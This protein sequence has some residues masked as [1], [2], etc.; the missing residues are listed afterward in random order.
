MRRTGASLLLAAL[1]AFLVAAL[2]VA[3]GRPAVAFAATAP[4]DVAALPSAGS[5]AVPS[6]HPAAGARILVRFTSAATAADEATAIADVGGWVDAAMPQLDLTRIALPVGDDGSAALIALEGDALVAT[7]ELDHRAALRFDPNDPYYATD[8]ITGLGQWGIRKALVNT[9]WDQ[10]RGSANVTVA[11]LDTG[12]DPGHPDLVSALVPGATFVSQPSTGCDPSATQ[13][14]DS[15]GTHVAGIIGASGNNGVGI[16]GVAFGVKIMAIK[17]LDCQGIGSLSDVAQGMVYAVDHGARIVNLSLGSP[18]DSTALQSAVQYATAKNVLVVSAAGN[19]GEMTGSCTSVDQIEYPA[20]YPQVLAVGATDTDDSIAFF[21]TQNSTVDV[22]APGRRIVSTTPRYATYLSARG[23]PQNYAAFSGTSQASPFVAGVAALILSGEPT[24]GPAQLMQR[25]ESTADQLQG[26]QGTRNDAYGYGRVNAF[27]AVAAGATVERFGATYDTSALPK[28][29]GLGAAYTAK[30]TVTNTSTFTWKAVDPGSTRLGWSF[31]GPL[32][33]PTGI[34]GSVPLPG[35]VL[36]GASA[37]V[38]FPVVAPTTA[39]PYLFRLDLSRAG[40]AF[41]SKGV[42]PGSLAVV[43]GS[44]IGATY[45]PTAQTS[46][47]AGTASFS[48]G[49]PSSVSV[50]VTN[51]GTTT[52]AAGG[53]TPVHLSYHWLQGGAVVVWDGQRAGLPSDVPAGA[54]VTVSLGVQPPPKA[55]TYTLRIDLVQEGV[56]WFSGLGVPPQDLAASVL[57]PFVASYAA[58]APPFLLPGGH[59]LLPVIVTNAGTATWPAGGA[60]PVHLAAHLIGPSGNVVVWD[61]ARTAFPI[62][63]PPGAVVQTNVVVDAPLAPGAYKLKIDLVQ[64]GVAWFSALGVPTQDLDLGVVADYRAQITPGGPLTLTGSMPAAQVTITNTGVATWT[65]GGAAPID[66]SAHWYDA[67]GRVLVWD[68]PRTALPQALGPNG[69][70]TIAV[71]LGTPPPGAAFV[72]IDLV[73][74][75]VAW[76]GQGAL[77]PV[78]F[79]P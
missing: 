56:A 49:T 11:V 29:V 6:S 38:A 21:S 15:H 23:T 18:Y 53:A 28:S 7:A 79:T 1:R 64:E 74:E 41:S 76:F 42:T 25:I 72:A 54:S 67:K 16:A 63:I 69:S 73:A 37:T 58:S 45:A 19:C 39:A 13:D 77:R 55:G 40:V 57:T 36:P 52:W 30:V 34:G 2:V 5:L 20:A 60:N 61:G 50:V 22:A 24:L 26:A 70:V 33:Q 3:I 44:G 71:A 31:T 12:V 9:A 27:R 47:A 32:G 51:T 78:T 62:D 14:D 75:G 17:V 48:L 4:A 43:A 59:T 66:I 68:G 8:P 46:T 10:R 35:D 65:T